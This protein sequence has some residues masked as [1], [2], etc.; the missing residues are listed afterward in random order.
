LKQ[1]RDRDGD[2]AYTDILEKALTE[3]GMADAA[4]VL[5]SY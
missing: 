5:T 1:W 2:E 3:S 4:I